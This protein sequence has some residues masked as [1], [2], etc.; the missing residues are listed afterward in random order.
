MS[1]PVLRIAARGDGVSASGRHIPFGVP[2]DMTDEA[3]TLVHG[4]HHQVPPCR[5]FPECGGCQLQHAD[6]AAYRDLRGTEAARRG[7][8][9]AEL[10]RAWMRRGTLHGT[11]TMLADQLAALEE[12]GVE[13]I[14]LQWLDLPD[15]DGMFSM[16]EAVLEA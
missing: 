6:D 13:R 12:A 1:D 7:I 11:P 8:G 15:H 14:Y 4:P 5:H 3:G 2:G 16:V 10:E 9:E